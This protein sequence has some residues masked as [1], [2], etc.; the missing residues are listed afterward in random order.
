[1]EEET[2]TLSCLNCGKEK[3]YSTKDPVGQGIFNAFC[4][5]DC[6]DEYSARL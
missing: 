6:E 3:E 1:M 2:I 5:G 4:D